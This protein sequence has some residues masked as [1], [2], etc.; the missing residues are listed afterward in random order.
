MLSHQRGA[1][2]GGRLAAL[3]GT[4]LT[5]PP[6]PRPSLPA[7]AV[8][9][10]R[11]GLSRRLPVDQWGHTTLSAIS[12]NTAPPAAASAGHG[13]PQRA[14][15]LPLPAH[16]LWRDDCLREPGWAARPLA[17]G[18][19]LHRAVVQAGRGALASAA[20][21]RPQP[22]LPINLLVDCCRPLLLADCPYEW[23]HFGC[24]G[25]TEE[26]RPKGKWYCRDCRRALGKK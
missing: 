1:A 22:K 14:K 20:A 24:V 15:V 5:T 7:Y 11:N 21:V 13:G 25:L 10:A 3:A 6:S 19:P 2:S 17:A 8:A 9:A 18:P 12:F 4:A 26:N 16:L 23:F